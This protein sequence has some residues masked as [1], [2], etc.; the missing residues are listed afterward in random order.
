M[1]RIQELEDYMSDYIPQFSLVY[2][3]CMI[4]FGLN[5]GVCPRFIY[6]ITAKYVSV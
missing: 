4:V 6:G 1:S 3:P 2:I 5:P